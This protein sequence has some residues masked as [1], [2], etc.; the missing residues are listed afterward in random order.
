M[1]LS[2]ILYLALLLTVAALRLLELRVSRNHQQQMI[3]RGAKKIIDPK[4]RW[5]VLVHTAVLLGAALEVVFLKRPFIAWL[6][7][8]ML[9]L[10]LAAN[11]VRWWVIR[12]MGQHW[13]V[14][15]VDSTQLGVVTSGPFR[16]VRHPNYAAVFVEM[17]AL[18]LI[19]TAWITAVAGAIA[20]VGV[21]AQR[22]SAEER[23]LFANA[24]YRAAMAGKPRF[25]PGMF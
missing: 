2:V 22:L 9:A 11:A 23:V 15:V 5:M 13:N 1:E 25:L 17:L 16:F 10:F 19:H 14:Q 8:P 6:A 18:P 3:A 20:H 12:T 21:L 4:F 24:D 7:A